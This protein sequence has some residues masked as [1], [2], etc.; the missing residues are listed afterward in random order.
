M[1]CVSCGGEMKKNIQLLFVMWN[2]GH[3]RRKSREKNATASE[4]EGNSQHYGA[5]GTHNIMVRSDR[6]QHFR[7]LPKLSP[8]KDN[9]I[10]NLRSLHLKFETYTFK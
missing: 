4:C 1:Y 7:S 3:R 10:L 8:R 9:Q 2:K 5:K 6:C